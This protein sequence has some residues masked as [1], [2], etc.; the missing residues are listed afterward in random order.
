MSVAALVGLVA[1]TVAAFADKAPAPYK[2]PAQASSRKPPPPPRAWLPDTFVLARIDDRA[3]QARDYDER[4]FNSHMEYRPTQDSVG[5]ADFLQRLV[6]KE[7]LA[8]VARAANYQLTFQERAQM[9]AFVQSTLG[10][11]LFERTVMDSVKVTDAEAESV[12][13]QMKREI[14]LARVRFGR[15][16][17]AE[18]MRRDL[19]A[20]HTSMARAWELRLRMPGDQTTSPDVGWQTW[21]NTPADVR[22]IFRLPVGGI[23]SPIAEPPG[24]S[25]YQVKEERTAGKLQVF[26]LYRGP[27]MRQLK[28]E[29]TDEVRE[30]QISG[31]RREA[32]IRLDSANVAWAAARFPHKITK[33]GASRVVLDATVPSFSPEDTA[34]TIATYRGGKVTVGRLV[35]IYRD[36]SEF[37]RPSLDTPEAIKQM[38]DAIVLEPRLAEIARQR[39]YDRDSVVIVVIERKREEVMVDHLYADS[40]EAHTFVPPA[41]RRKY[42]E[43]YQQRF[44]TSPNARYAMFYLPNQQGADSIATRLRKGVK[45]EKILREDSLR[46]VARGRIQARRRDDIDNPFFRQVFFDMKVGDIMRVGPDPD[47]GTYN[48]IQLLYRDSGKPVPF[49]EADVQIDEYLRQEASEKLLHEFIAR[50]SKRM[51]IESHPELVMQI[52][53]V[54]PATE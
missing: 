48:V 13:V 34:R 23:S 17:T 40:I 9:E 39:G 43:K 52:R 42:Y 44:V 7:V 12:Y 49:D 27:I 37:M 53:L 46:G 32:G 16:E 47:N 20:G 19:V 14:R 15:I 41:E 30:R 54:D 33:E 11:R 6:D 4:F 38:V 8:S 35:D 25:L 26:P 10:N 3:I 31:L 21:N 2:P 24:F 29:K 18:R 45:A 36:I 1:G 5:R 22:P 51:K 50:H 28:Q